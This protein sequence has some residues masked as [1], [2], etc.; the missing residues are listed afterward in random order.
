MVKAVDHVYFVGGIFISPII[1][2]VWIPTTYGTDVFHT[3]ISAAV[4]WK[5]LL[6]KTQKPK[7]VVHFIN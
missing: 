7:N 3:I 5:S 1:I 6:T 4:L 2:Y